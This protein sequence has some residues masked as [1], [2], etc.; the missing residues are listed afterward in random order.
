MMLSLFCRFFFCSIRRRHTRCALVTGV[1]TCALPI[2]VAGLKVEIIAGPIE[3]R[4]HRRNKV[5]TMLLA[6]SLA[7]L[8]P[9]YFCNGVPFVCRFKGPGQRSEERSVGKECGSTCSSRW[10][11]DH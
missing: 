4:R 10:S 1:Q 11:A 9:R 6:I 3:I 2:Y 7:Q 5:A 8:D